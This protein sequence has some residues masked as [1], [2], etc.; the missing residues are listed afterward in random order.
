MAGLPEETQGA[1]LET[2]G[3]N[4]PLPDVPISSWTFLFE[5]IAKLTDREIQMILREIDTKDLTVALLGTSAEL[6]NR[7]LSNLSDRVGKMI[8][9]EM[10]Y[11]GPMHPR[12]IV[13]IQLRIIHIILQLQ[14]AG[15]VTIT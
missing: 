13:A 4:E 7:F 3:E 12:D 14:E 2:L 5:D 8:S 9:E 6:R 11:M 1:I 10:A 15:Q